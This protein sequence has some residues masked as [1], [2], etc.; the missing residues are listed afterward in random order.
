M[1]Q[2]TPLTKEYF[3]GFIERKFDE[4]LSPYVTK[5]YFE[6][7][8]EKKFDEKLKPLATKDEL[9]V[10]ISKLAT[11]DELGFA[12]SKL[13]TKDELNVSISKLATKDEMTKSIDDL[14]IATLKG[15]REVHNRLDVFDGKF[16][17][18]EESMKD[19]RLDIYETETRLGT[20][21]DK[22]DKR[23]DKIDQYIGHMEIRT[24][25]LDKIILQDHS[26]RIRV[27]EKAVGV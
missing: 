7:I 27:L 14:A 8:L 3:E 19:I 24:L 15:F 11:K 4:K 12:I 25:N 22:L 20:K 16:T 26:P 23:I 10:S 5:E 1:Q 9:N 21:I 6:E 2:G 17:E 13:A 18:M